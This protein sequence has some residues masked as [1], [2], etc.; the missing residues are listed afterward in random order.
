MSRV[1]W[2][3][4]VRRFV[5]ISTISVH[6]DPQPDGLHEDSP[7]ATD[8]AHAYV[9]TKAAGEAALGMVRSQG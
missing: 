4:G 3:T 2:R 5:H 7:L 6:G 1:R 8:A 9:A